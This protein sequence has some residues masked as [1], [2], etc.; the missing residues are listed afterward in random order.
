MSQP[1]TVA[2]SSA[3]RKERPS[4]WVGSAVTPAT[5]S[6]VGVRSAQLT[7]IVE[8]GLRAGEGGA[9][10]G[11]IENKGV[12]VVADGLEEGDEAADALVEARDSLIV[13]GEFGAAGGRVGQIR[14]HVHVGR[15]IAHRIDGGIAGRAIAEGVGLRIGVEGGLT[16]GQNG[17]RAMRIV[18]REVE[19]KRAGVLGLD[20]LAGALGHF[21]GAAA[22][23]GGIVGGTAGQDGLK[24]VG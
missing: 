24:R 19:E 15:T 2:P 23:G 22:D 12:L 18:A 11:E 14:G 4:N 9:V 3:A 16:A 13:F 8:R 17:V 1:D 7:G 10:I 21:H 6:N 5:S 20:D